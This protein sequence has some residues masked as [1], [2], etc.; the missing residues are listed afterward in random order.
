MSEKFSKDVIYLVED[1]KSI[2]YKYEK[3]YDKLDGNIQICSYEYDAPILKEQCRII[4]KKPLSKG[5]I[6][7]KHPYE[8][9]CYIHIEESEDV[10]F[11]YKCNKISDIAR[12]L[13]ASKCKTTL[14]LQE[15][16]E[17][18]FEINGGT[19]T[20]KASL[21]MYY[22]TEES[23]KLTKKYATEDIYAEGN[24]SFTQEGYEEAQKIAKLFNDL[25]IHGLVEKRSP[26][27]PN[28]LKKRTVSVELATEFNH[29]L[30]CAITLKAL[31]I[32]AL[33]AQINKIVKESKKV[34]FKMEVEFY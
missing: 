16:G 1:E 4:S 14:E 15:E 7:I 31:P 2:N 5:D 6:L 13:G 30:D 33:S 21:D 17:R 25:D 26:N 32:F 27:H 34:L 19:T 29:S 9:N 8:D 3:N 12:L 11:K 20:K 18:T 28:L 23:N 22:K 24:L 10:I